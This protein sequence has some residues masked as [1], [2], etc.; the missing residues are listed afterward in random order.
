MPRENKLLKSIDEK[1]I[2]SVFD[3][4]GPELE[5]ISWR[6]KNSVWKE[7]MSL[8]HVNNTKKSRKSIYTLWRNRKKKAVQKSAEDMQ[9]LQPEHVQESVQDE[10]PNLL[11]ENGKNIDIT[12]KN[13][14]INL[15]LEEHFPDSQFGVLTESTKMYTASK[16]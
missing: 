15:E 13:E 12:N 1:L 5:K 16:L 14:S 11:E 10:S 9:E 2:E 3:K 8:F 7:I 4:F 6:E